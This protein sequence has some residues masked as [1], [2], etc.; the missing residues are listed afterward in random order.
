MPST[1]RRSDGNTKKSPNLIS[2][3]DAA[4]LRGVTRGAVTHACAVD[5]PLY[6]AVR[7]RYLDRSTA[8]FQSWLSGGETTVLRE[9]MMRKRRVE[10]ERLETRSL[11]EQGALISRAL[12]K[13][14]VLGLIQEL[15]LRLLR[16]APITIAARIGAAA[17]SGATNEELVRLT[18]S[19]I[20][21]ELE[22]AKRR[23]VDA[24]R[25]CRVNGDP[26]PMEDV[27]V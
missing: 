10:I 6:E 21:P 9:L 1:R 17:R 25:R 8:A 23:S 16:Y 18:L 24:L 13:T 3:S 27:D 26:P 11:R 19:I 20:Q 14:H 7:G 22:G 15:F 12:V 2:R 5:G 4:A